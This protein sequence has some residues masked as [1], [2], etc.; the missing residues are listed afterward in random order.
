MGNITCTDDDMLQTFVAPLS[1]D[2]DRA[3]KI[4]MNLPTNSHNPVAPQSGP[5]RLTKSVQALQFDGA[6]RMHSL[7]KLG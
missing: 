5:V 2:C 3:Y 1:R 7:Y 6:K 4:K